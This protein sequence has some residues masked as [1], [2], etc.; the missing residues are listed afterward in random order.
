MA[1]GRAA[2]MAAVPVPEICAICGE[3][4]LYAWWLD[5]VPGENGQ[6]ERFAW[7]VSFQG[8][9]KEKSADRPWEVE[10]TRCK[11]CTWWARRA[12]RGKYVVTE[13]GLEPREW[14]RCFVHV[15]RA[16]PGTAECPRGEA[17]WSYFTSA[18]GAAAATGT[19]EEAK[20]GWFLLFRCPR[21]SY[22]DLSTTEARKM[23]FGGEQKTTEKPDGTGRLGW[24]YRSCMESDPRLAEGVEKG[25]L[26]GDAV[27]RPT[28]RFGEILIRRPALRSG[29][30]SAVEIERKEWP[31][32]IRRRMRALA[33]EKESVCQRCAER[34]NRDLTDFMMDLAGIPEAE[35]PSYVEQGDRT[36]EYRERMDEETK[37]KRRRKQG[38][39]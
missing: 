22:V 39:C 20:G 25:D 6:G 17:R 13:D 2:K 37:P 10:I 31:R 9:A 38:P 8:A 23:A 15:A 35:R 7:K 4:V 26:P 3:G 5:P 34:L 11:N 19:R 12:D 1:G 27:I 14:H 24:T 32:G 16:T 30:V 28:R 21:R 33:S 36:R 29:L 18:G